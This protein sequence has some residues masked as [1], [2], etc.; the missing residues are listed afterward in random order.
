MRWLPAVA[1]SFVLSVLP[2]CSNHVGG[3]QDKVA[4]R[5]S[6]TDSPY[7]V[8][9]KL[10]RL[11]EGS[12][13]LNHV[14][15]SLKMGKDGFLYFGVGDNSANG[16]LL[17]F[18]P[19]TERFTDLGDF[20][21]ALAASIRG[22]GNYGKFHVGPH[23]TN[24]GSVYFASYAREYWPGKQAGRCLRY[25]ESEGIGDLGR[26]T[27]AST[28]CTA[29]TCTTSSTWPTTILTLRFTILPAAPGRTKAA[30]RASRRSSA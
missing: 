8:E 27:R 14:T 21:S 28:S 9:I 25:R 2:S 1:V 17:R 4:V 7:E 16:N 29:T 13:H 3:G 23:Q 30:S 20:K 26:T 18:D 6:R 22:E 24:D 19:A 10:F 11:P 15:Y 12:R 5:T